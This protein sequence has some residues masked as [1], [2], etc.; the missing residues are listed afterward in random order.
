MV[1]PSTGPPAF[2]TCSPCISGPQGLAFSS[3]SQS[4]SLAPEPFFLSWQQPLPRGK[5]KLQGQ[6]GR[7]LK[8]RE[9][10]GEG[11]G[12]SWQAV[13]PTPD[14]VLGARARDVLVQGEVGEPCQV[15]VGGPRPP[16]EDKGDGWHPVHIAFWPLLKTVSLGQRVCSGP[17]AQVNQSSPLHSQNS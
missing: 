13:F 3:A 11:G 17:S 8:P 2:L 6:C 10:P 14:P 1:H 5:E 7:N 16:S 9:Q 15:G 4:L 12:A